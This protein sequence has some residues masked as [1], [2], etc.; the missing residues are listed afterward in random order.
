MSDK[1]EA[2]E[3]QETEKAAP[4]WAERAISFNWLNEFLILA[5]IAILLAKAYP[6]LGAE[7]LQ[8]QITA[9]WIA[10]IFIFGAFW[11]N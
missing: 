5:V 4:T 10:V 8:P 3:P 7:Y 9:K 11:Y 6:P 2:M 1:G